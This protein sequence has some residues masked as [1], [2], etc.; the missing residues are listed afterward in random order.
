MTFTLPEVLRKGGSC[1]IGYRDDQLHRAML[2]LP[3][4]DDVHCAV[5]GLLF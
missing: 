2:K 3:I 5:Y 4:C 1:F